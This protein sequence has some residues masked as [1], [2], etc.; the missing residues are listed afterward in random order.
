M[1]CLVSIL[2]NYRKSGVEAECTYPSCPNCRN[3]DI[4]F[5]T[6]LADAGLIPR[7]KIK[8]F[9][10]LPIDTSLP[11]SKRR[12]IINDND[13]DKNNDGSKKNSS[14]HKVLSYLSS[15]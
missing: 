7:N 4:P 14:N 2:H 13:H 5:R 9:K 8:C 15:S 1:S 12:K 11:R 6:V 3:D 10:P